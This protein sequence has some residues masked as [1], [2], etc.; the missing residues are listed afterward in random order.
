MSTTPSKQV[1]NIP[2]LYYYPN[3]L[4]PTQVKNITTDLKNSSKWKGVTASA[5]SRQVIQYG[6]EYSYSG[7]DLQS[8]DPIP[9]LYALFTD[10][11]QMDPELQQVLANWQP[12]QLLINRYL[13][14]QGISAHTDHVRQFGPIVVAITL[15]SGIEMEFTKGT[16]KVNVY[17]EPNS[18]YVMSGDARYKWRHAIIPRKSDVVNGQVI[19]RGI[20]DSLTY[21]TTFQAP[22]K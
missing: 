17:V 15:G 6:Y 1:A 18:L 21:R 16:E 12:D 9:P 11:S 13:P 5:R 3:F 14:G 2:G 22:P 20:R 4:T 10:R 7:G 8:I 19:P